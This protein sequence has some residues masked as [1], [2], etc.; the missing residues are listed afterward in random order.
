MSR[1]LALAVLAAGLF[2]M[3]G[4]SVAT[5][6]L[7]PGYVDPKPL[8]DAAIRT[9]G[10]DKLNCVTIAGEGYN[11]AVGQ[12]KEAGKNVDWPRPDKLGNYVRTMNWQA[13]TMKE[14]FDRKPGL[15][16][17]AWKYGVGWVDGPLQKE[18]H[19]IHML[20][21]SGPK[22]YAWHM[23]GATGQPLP[24]DQDVADVY[25]IELW[26]NPHGFLK[27]AQMPGAN[28]K[29]SWRWELGEMG[30]DG[31]TI[32]PE[33]TN[34]VQIK[35]PGGFQIDAT[36]NKEHM[37]QRMH[38]LVPDEFFGDLNY[39]HE[40]TNESYIDIGN[41]IKFPTGWH[42]HEGYDDNFQAQNYSAGHNAFGG[43]MKDVKANVCPDAVAVPDAIRSFQPQV[44]PTMTKLA[45]NV[46]SYER[47]NYK[48]IAVEF[49]RWIAMFEAP[50]SEDFN[51]RVADMIVKQI[52][53]KPIRYVV[54]S[55]QHA[56]AAGGLR[57]YS[58]LG[59]TILTSFHNIELF[60]RDFINYQARTMKP[61][62]VSQWPPTELAE[63]YYWE[64]I[65]ENY[66]LEDQGRVMHM[67]YIN[68]LQHSEGMLVAYLPR[69]KMLIEN[70]IINTNNLPAMPT[71][72]MTTLYRQITALKLDVQQIVPIHGQ[73]MS[74]SDFAK[75]FPA[76]P[77]QTASAQ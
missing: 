70:D 9:I 56:D 15:T 76:Q 75:M 64:D 58:H 6:Q 30:R 1:R 77:R 59:A 37:L 29:A 39:E 2:A 26:M 49:P 50:R 68:P 61:D 44:N 23:D 72:D 71:R 67:Y 35:V 3:A 32:I 16:P 45:D 55:H 22:V 21:A 17:A 51:L 62:M 52:P 19:Q 28:A 25:P 11:G 5:Q 13:K 69:E 20:N 36:I 42:S 46:Y 18:T 33:I 41:G 73:P 14:E 66:T 43:T 57:A 74:W 40:F 24:V 54:N 48:T 34:V 65:R 10:N 8:L 38:T 7:P 31:L 63:G 60:R 4:G 12:Q 27:A 47:A 53:N